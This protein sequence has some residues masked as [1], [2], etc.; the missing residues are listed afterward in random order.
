[1][2]FSPLIFGDYIFNLIEKI[3]H[4]FQ[5]CNAGGVIKKNPGG[6]GGALHTRKP[7]NG[8]SCYYFFTLVGAVEARRVQV[9]GLDL[10]CLCTVQ[11]YWQIRGHF[12]EKKIIF[13]VYFDRNNN[14]ISFF[15]NERESCLY[16]QCTPL[17]F[18]T[19][20]TWIS[21]HHSPW[22]PFSPQFEICS[23]FWRYF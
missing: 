23:C 19:L 14:N 20:P 16:H 12:H 2:V 8:R 6:E 7:G 22:I 11:G 21:A 15:L 5:R 18:C 17:R 10:T 4:T 13:I 1:M 3:S 9:R